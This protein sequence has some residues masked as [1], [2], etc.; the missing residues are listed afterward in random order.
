MNIQKLLILILLTA[1]LEGC[2][3]KASPVLANLEKSA[4]SYTEEDI[5]TQITA[6]LTITDSD[7]NKLSGATIQIKENYQNAEDEL[8]YNARLPIN[9][10]VNIDTDTGTL[11]L[12]GSASL[13]DYQ[14]AL[15]AITYRNTNTTTPTLSIRT[16][17]FTVNNGTKNSNS[18]TRNIKVVAAN[19]A[20]V[21][22]STKDKSGNTGDINLDA[23]L[24]D[25]GAPNGV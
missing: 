7:S 14:T 23:V 13:S 15:R 17:S 12:S 16:V 9:L 21:L 22:D 10:N 3:D 4:L 2:G 1:L 8:G 5:A 6:T 24:E 18:V 25:A 11:T 20:P 19:D